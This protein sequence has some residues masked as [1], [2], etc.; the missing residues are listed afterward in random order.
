ML[1]PF[2]SLFQLFQKPSPVRSAT[3][4]SLR[5]LAEDVFWPLRPQCQR[6]AV[7]TTID[8]PSNLTITA[9]RK[10]ICRAVENLMRHAIAAM[11]DG[12]TLTVTAIVGRDV[13]ELEIADTGASFSD[14]ARLHVFDPSATP[15]EYAPNADSRE[16]TAVHRI[17]ELHGGDVTVANCPEGGVAF[18]LR[19]PQRRALEAAA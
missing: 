8:I 4:F 17:A 9:N 16:L 13:V 6:Q 12:G 2:N 3:S 7:K 10:L 18:T 5:E 1:L 11:P 19:L 15:V 14:A